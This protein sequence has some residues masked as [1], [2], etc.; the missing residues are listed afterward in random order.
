MTMARLIW[1]KST[2][3]AWL[4]LNTFNLAKCFTNPGVYVIWHGGFSPW[5]VRVGQGDVADRIGCHR[6]DSDVQAYASL[7]LYVTWAAVPANQVD[8]V[9]RY[10]AEA[11]KP[12]VGS[13]WPNVAT[14][15]VNLP[16][17]A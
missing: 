17:A 10:L 13:R 2:E 8:G 7:G 4:P 14:I 11:L 12:K 9:E 6:G 15:P 3:D 5:T 16:W 1:V